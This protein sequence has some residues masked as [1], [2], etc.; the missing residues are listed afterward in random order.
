[1]YVYQ[2]DKLYVQH[3]NDL[4]GVEIYPDEVIV[5]KD[6]KTVLG[7]EFELLT[8]VEVQARFN[9]GYKF[10]KKE[11]KANVAIGKAKAST[12]KSTGK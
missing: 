7:K 2:N 11:V 1:M 10:P 6:E 12:R 4:F 3:E 9:E 8:P 5:L